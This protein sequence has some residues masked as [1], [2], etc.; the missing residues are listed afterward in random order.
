MV[1]NKIL[2]VCQTLCIKKEFAHALDLKQPYISEVEK[3]LTSISLETLKKMLD[4]NNRYKNGDKTK[5]HLSEKTTSNAQQPD[6]LS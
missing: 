1:S 6:Y 3:D 4:W 2:V 5:L